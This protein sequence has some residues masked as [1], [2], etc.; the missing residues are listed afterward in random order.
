MCARNICVMFPVLDNKM[1]GALLVAFRVASYLIKKRM[2][3]KVVDYKGGLLYKLLLDRELEF[4][5]V[6]LDE[7]GWSQRIKDTDVVL[8]FNNDIYTYPFV[9]SGN[10]YIYIYDVYPPFWKRFLRPKGVPLIGT[11]RFIKKLARENFFNTALAVMESVSKHNIENRFASAVTSD[12]KSLPILPVSIDVNKNGYKKTSNKK[13]RI[14]YIGRSEVWKITPLVK[15]IRDFKSLGGGKDFI[16]NIVVSDA[17][18]AKKI[19]N[20]FGLEVEELSFSFFENIDADS[21][22]YIIRNN[23]DIGFAMGTSALELASRG[24]P[25]VLVDFSSREIPAHYK[26]QW[27][28][29]VEGF[30]LGLDLD[31]PL[32][33]NRL[34]KGISMAGVLNEFM[35]D[36][37]MLSEKCYMYVLRNHSLDLNYSRLVEL[38]LSSKF[39]SKSLRSH[40]TFL[41]YL[42]QLLRKRLI[43][44]AK[45]ER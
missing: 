35:Y 25:T 27:I 8:G 11:K 13:I 24:I 14:T 19:I 2:G 21:L 29:Q 40:L 10:P 39:R 33:N 1:S 38:A 28:F 12:L 18:K 44:R 41:F 15:I 45:Y 26:Y 22:D 3:V 37:E 36:S 34:E 17:H 23:T 32:N 16:F 43:G 42:F 31:D 7:Y 30:T 4:E 6:D 20:E 5:F 9:F